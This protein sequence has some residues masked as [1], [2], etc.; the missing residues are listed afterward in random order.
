MAADIDH[1]E[2]TIYRINK[3]ELINSDYNCVQCI[4][5]KNQ[6]KEIVEELKS[7]RLIIELLQQKS[8]TII[9]SKQDDSNRNSISYGVSSQAINAEWVEVSSKCNGSINKDRQIIIITKKGADLGKY[10]TYNLK[11]IFSFPRC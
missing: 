9:S 3:S 2:E 11:L 10:A 8:S 1:A 6:L 4:E 5:L 7:A